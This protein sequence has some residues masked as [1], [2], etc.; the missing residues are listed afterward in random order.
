MLLVTSCHKKWDK[1]RPGG[2]LMAC[3]QIG[4]DT[5]LDHNDLAKEK[6]A[7]QNFA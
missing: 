3:M 5:S 2:L 1:L 6:H 4:Q 7:C